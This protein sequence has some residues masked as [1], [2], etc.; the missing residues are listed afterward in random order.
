MF[1]QRTAACKVNADRYTP[2]FLVSSAPVLSWP[3]CVCWSGTGRTL[4]RWR[5][6]AATV[7]PSAHE[8][9]PPSS[10]CG[11][12]SPWCARWWPSRSQRHGRSTVAPVRMPAPACTSD[13]AWD[14]AR[15]TPCDRS[16]RE[17]EPRNRR[18]R[19][20]SERC[21]PRSFDTA[22]LSY[23]A[24]ARRLYGIDVH[25][26]RTACSTVNM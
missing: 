14:A 15:G 26:S 10:V 21:R 25:R 18:P 23:A 9:P 12:A 1:S 5:R 24:S 11:C 19:R 17:C 6:S 3:R 7:A 2:W 4:R 16:T 13:P 22:R 20:V 8:G